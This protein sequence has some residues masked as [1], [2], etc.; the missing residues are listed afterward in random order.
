VAGTTTGFY[1]P[2]HRALVD[3]WLALAVMLGYWGVVGAAFS[4]AEGRPSPWAI[5][6]IYIAGGV[7][8]LVKGP[9]GPA[10]LAGPAFVAI[11]VGRRWGF[12]RSWAHAPG[13]V[14]FLGLCALWPLM[15]YQRG[16]TEL[17][18][19]FVIDNIV[20][21]F[22]PGAEGADLGGH[23][24]P[25]WYYVRTLPVAMLP[26]L[27]VVPAVCVWLRKRRIPSEWNRAGLLFLASVLPVGTLLLSIP[28]TKRQLYLLPLFGPFGALVGMWL[29][30][31][32]ED[33][34]T[35]DHR[36]LAVVF[37]LVCV[38]FVAILGIVGAVCIGGQTGLDRVHVVMRSTPNLTLIIP[39]LAALALAVVGLG[40]RARKQRPLVVWTV[41]A[42]F[43]LGAPVVFH[44]VDTFKNLHHF[45]AG[46]AGSGAL[47]PDLI[48]YKMDEVT[49]GLVPFDTGIV[50][51][52]IPENDD[53]KDAKDQL[54]RA[55]ATGEVT[56]L[57]LIERRAK[58]VPEELRPRLRE[59]Q[60]WPYTKRRCYVLYEVTAQ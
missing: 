57:L 36:S 20:N 53:D 50:P 43:V 59:V 32:W 31:T 23:K 56:H 58:Y 4:R 46:L 60:K 19:G 40:L 42:L 41:L 45:T 38:L 5:L 14:L 49:R 29:D 16:G 2:F 15:L 21:R 54:R 24:N 48:C 27:L 39:L 11:V 51:R 9:V 33:A 13:A 8:F 44:V 26:W 35:L 34:Q 47:S 22:L 12:F 37:G 7:A 1:I 30:A 55:V 25:P 28:G 6:I 17:M 18:N 52:H 10:L 3:P